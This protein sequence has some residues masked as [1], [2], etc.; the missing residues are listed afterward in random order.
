MMAKPLEL[1]KV[2]LDYSLNG[3]EEDTVLYVSD[4]IFNWICYVIICKFYIFF[5]RCELIRIRK[6]E[7]IKYNLVSCQCAYLTIS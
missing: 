5:A 6:H 4:S 2:N 1:E 3:Q 7:K